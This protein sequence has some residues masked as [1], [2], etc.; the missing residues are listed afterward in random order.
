MLF[1]AC[2]GTPRQTVNLRAIRVLE[3]SPR[4]A[5]I[6]KWWSN[7]QDVILDMFAGSGTT[8]EAAKLLGRSAI[9]IEIEEKYCE[10]AAKRLSQE[11]LPLEVA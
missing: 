6:V 10:I 1:L 9:G 11:A 4:C 3:N 7:P 5:S 2:S 8:L